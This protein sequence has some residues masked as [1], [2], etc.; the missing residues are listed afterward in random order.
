MW[1]K[2]LRKVRYVFL[3]KEGMKNEKSYAWSGFSKVGLNLVGQMDFLR[4]GLELDLLSPSKV[5]LK[6]CFW[7]QIAWV[8]LPLSDLYLLLRS[9]V[10]LVEE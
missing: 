1:K 3:V 8:S 9:F 7:Q 4:N 5:F 10:T 6:C 2:V